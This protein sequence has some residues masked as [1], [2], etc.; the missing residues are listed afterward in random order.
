MVPPGQSQ[1]LDFC[2][3][4]VAKKDVEVK[5]TVASAEGEHLAAGSGVHLLSFS[6]TACEIVVM[7][8]S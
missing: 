2:T 6:L 4:L 8:G 1:L 7:C 3:F 5:L